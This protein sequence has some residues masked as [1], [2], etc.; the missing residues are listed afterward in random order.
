[1]VLACD[2][3]WDVA[4]NDMVLFLPPSLS[5]CLPPP[6]NPLFFAYFLRTNQLHN[7]FLRHTYAHCTSLV[8][9]HIRRT[10]FTPKYPSHT[11]LRCSKRARTLSLPFSLSRERAL[12]LSHTHPHTPGLGASAAAYVRERAQASSAGADHIRHPQR[13]QRQRDMHDRCT[14]AR[15]C[16]PGYGRCVMI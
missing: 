12:S 1:M 13:E 9:T 6:P 2:G 14:A 3:L 15:L 16:R 4:D 11:L 8:C 7:P 5:V 10:F